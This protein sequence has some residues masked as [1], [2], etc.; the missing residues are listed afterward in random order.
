MIVPNTLSQVAVVPVM[1]GL[2]LRPR[3]VIAW[4]ELDGRMVPLT[5]IVLDDR[6]VLLYPPNVMVEP[7]RYGPGDMRGWFRDIDTGYE[8]E[9]VDNLPE[10]WSE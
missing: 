9:F 2:L 1:D 7:G 8:R 4:K 3:P 5:D 10:W 6:F